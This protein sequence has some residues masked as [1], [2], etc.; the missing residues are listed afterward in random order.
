MF[1]QSIVNSILIGGVLILIAMGLTIILGIM[2]VVNFA[3]GEFYM[4][5]GFG[6]WYFSAEKGW[7]FPLALLT[8]VMIVGCIGFIIERGLFK[9]FRENA[10]PCLIISL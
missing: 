1:L 3:H 5:G 8:S 7:S 4:L 6:I 10:F 2:K 9:P